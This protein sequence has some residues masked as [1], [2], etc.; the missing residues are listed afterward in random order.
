M[1]NTES[2][3][4]MYLVS[5]DNLRSFGEKIANDV[6]QQAIGMLKAERNEKNLFKASEVTER[7]G[8]SSTTLWR[9]EKQGVLKS[10]KVG[11]RNYYRVAEIER[12][13]RGEV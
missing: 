7:Y 2:G 9:W 10:V 6:L 5:E 3:T 4:P 11:S 8:I 12:I 13:M 1:L